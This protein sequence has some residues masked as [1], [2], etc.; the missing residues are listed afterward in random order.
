[1]AWINP[2]TNWNP[3]DG[4]MAEDLNRAEE[5]TLNIRNIMRRSF[6]FG[7]KADDVTMPINRPHIAAIAMIHLRPEYRSLATIAGVFPSRTTDAAFLVLRD[8]P[9]TGVYPTWAQLTNGARYSIDFRVNP[10]LLWALPD[11]NVPTDCYAHLGFVNTFESVN[12]ET[13]H[14]IYATIAPYPYA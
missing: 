14:Q 2:K 1:M 10:M 3:G 6:S 12:L 9:Y 8:A 4:I 7:G 5:N 13:Y 11:V